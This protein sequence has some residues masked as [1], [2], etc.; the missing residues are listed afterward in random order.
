MELGDLASDLRLFVIFGIV[1]AM[2][3]GSI[4][5]IAAELTIVILILQMTASLHGLKIHK[6]DF[7]SEFKPAV[8]SV[9]CC[10]VIGTAS[11]LA[12]GLFFINSDEAVWYG[13]VMLASVP[14]AVS[15]ISIAMMMKGNMSMSMISMVFIYVIAFALTPILTHRLIGEAISPFEILESIVLF[16]AVPVILNF[17][18]SKF[19]IKKKHKVIFINCTI[20]LLIIIAFGECKECLLDDIGLLFI[21]IVLCAVRTFGVGAVMMYVLRKKGVPRENIVIYTGFSV[22]KSSGLACSMC[23]LLLDPFPEAALVCT[24]SVVVEFVWFAITNKSI[25]KYWPAD[26]CS[27]DMK[28][29]QVSG[30]RD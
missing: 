12:M 3:V 13:W 5:S 6:E 22:W 17:P 27:V 20:C 11:A 28:E 23:L 21:L 10:F 26:D 7:R 29:S 14:A 19:Q 18:L 2:V 24:T 8:F 16:I 30:Y 9:I 1:F 25:A 15:V 4:G